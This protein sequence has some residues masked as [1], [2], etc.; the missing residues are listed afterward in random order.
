MAETSSLSLVVYRKPSVETGHVYL[1][2]DEREQE[3]EKMEGLLDELGLNVEIGGD[4]KSEENLV[5]RLVDRM[6]VDNFTI[7]IS[8]EHL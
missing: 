4:Q 3:C 7:T 5:I 8:L 1:L 6:Y 2:F